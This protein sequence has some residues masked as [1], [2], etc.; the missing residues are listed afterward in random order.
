VT[1]HD[2]GAPAELFGHP[3]ALVPRYFVTALMGLGRTGMV[4]G[5]ENGL[6]A[7]VDFIGPPSLLPNKPDAWMVQYI[8]RIN[9]LLASSDTLRTPRNLKFIDGRHGALLAAHRA[10]AGERLL[11]FANLD[12][13][14]PHWLDVDL[15]ALTGA[16]HHRLDNALDDEPPAF[17]GAA[18]R[19]T[20]PPCGVQAL[21]LWAT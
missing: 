8:G 20:I 16:S 10:S 4:Q 18:H 13:A 2:T 5:N 21:R 1:T 7:K 6:P 9:R 15:S 19:F 11:L 14:N 12:T 3:R 17:A